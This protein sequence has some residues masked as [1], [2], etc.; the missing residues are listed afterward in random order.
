MNVKDLTEAKNITLRKASGTKGGEYHSPCPGCGGEDRFHVWPAQNNG[1]GSW[2]CRGCD[3]GGDNI[4]FLREFDGMSFKEAAQAVGRTLTGRAYKRPTFAE[5]VKR[6]VQAGGNDW[7]PDP[8]PSRDCQNAEIWVQHVQKLVTSGH[9]LLMNTPE[10]LRQLEER[11]LCVD[12]CRRYML[13]LVPVSDGKTATFRYRESW[14]LEKIVK[15]DGKPKMLWIPRGILIPFYKDGVVHRVKIRRPNED[16]RPDFDLK[17]YALPGSGKA[18]MH[19][20][21]NPKYFVVVEAELD[22][23]MIYHKASD[24]ISALPLGS[25]SV[26][27]DA[28]THKA[29]SQAEKIL[30]ALDADKAGADAWRFWQANYRQAVRWPVPS[31]KDP[32]DAVKAGV[33]IRAWI[34]AGL[35]PSARYSRQ[36]SRQESAPVPPREEP[37]PITESDFVGESIAPPPVTE[38]E[39]A[40]GS[41][42]PP[43]S[44]PE[45]NIDRLFG[46]LK[47]YPVKIEFSESR[48]RIIPYRRLGDATMKQISNL[49]FFDADVSGYLAGHPADVISRSNFYAN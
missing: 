30:V 25:A 33:D 34:M 44:E 24:L 14:G 21:G 43:P 23:L 45:D 5:R 29:L 37:P 47:R 38:P 35:P 20:P 46:I 10:Y 4:A 9:E 11:G 28:E 7:H 8:T 48:T 32:G 1:S 26:R 42:A 49:I 3:K 39:I 22:G 6:S 31:A 15:K 16:L 12:A 17:Y 36:M 13:G 27:P 40:G 19:L 2:W 41:I 18:M